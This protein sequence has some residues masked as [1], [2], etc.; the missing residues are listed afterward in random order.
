[1]VEFALIITGGLLIF[2]LLAELAERKQKIKQKE[3]E[4]YEEACHQ[5]DIYTGAPDEDDSRS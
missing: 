5:H 4:I 1:M 2:V 3:N